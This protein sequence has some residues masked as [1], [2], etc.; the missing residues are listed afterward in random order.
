MVT[1]LS[2]VHFGDLQEGIK[3]TFLIPKANMV[4][5]RWFYCGGAGTESF[6]CTFKMY[7]QIEERRHNY[8]F[9]VLNTKLG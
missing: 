7:F 9:K 1:E 8:I 4:P 2:G 5:W 6:E 3:V